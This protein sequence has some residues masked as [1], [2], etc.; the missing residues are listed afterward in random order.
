GE[1]LTLNYTIDS[2]AGSPTQGQFIVSGGSLAGNPNL[3]PWRSQNL[4]LSA[5]WYLGSAS[6]LSLGLFKVEIDSFT[7]SS[8]VMMD[9]PDA[10]GIV[11]RQVPI[12]TLVQGEGGTL[13]GVEIAA[14]LAFGDFMDGFISNFGIDTNYTYSPSEG[15]NKDIFGETNM[16]VD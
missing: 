11:R 7:E 15:S 5:E 9:Q 13:E 2:T 14:K 8:S 12:N 3:D 10:D 16:F 6:V 4:D 1:G